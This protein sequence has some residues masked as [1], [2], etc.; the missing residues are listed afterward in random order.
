MVINDHGCCS[1]VVVNSVFFFHTFLMDT[2]FIFHCNTNKHAYMVCETW[3]AVLYTVSVNI[4]IYCQG[5]VF[6]EVDFE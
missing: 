2:F 1:C 3:L 5:F 6:G 4:R